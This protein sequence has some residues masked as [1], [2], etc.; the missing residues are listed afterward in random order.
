[1]RLNLDGIRKKLSNEKPASVFLCTGRTSHQQNPLF[2]P[3]CAALKETQVHHVRVDRRSLWID[4]FWHLLQ[5]IKSRPPPEWLVAFG[6][7]TVIDTAK[8]ICAFWNL[9]LSS[10]EEFRKHVESNRIAPTP[11][12]PLC[13]IPTT[14]GTGSEATQ[15]AVC[16]VGME[17]YSLDH[18]SLLPKDHLLDSRAIRALDSTVRAHTFLDAVCQATESLWAVGSTQESQKYAMDALERLLANGLRSFS[19]T[20]S[21][22][23]LFAGLEGAHLAG[24]AINISRTTAPHALSYYLTARHD[25]PHG[26]AVSTTFSELARLNFEVGQDDCLDPA[27]PNALRNR[28]DLIFSAWRCSSIDEFCRNF[29]ALRKELGVAARFHDLG[30]SPEEFE[31]FLSHLPNPER[32]KN[33]PRRI[34]PNMIREVLTPLF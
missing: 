12:A 19:A 18:P 13:A 14:A 8:L 20:A 6:G 24:K 25:M 11:L 31:S 17:K 28:F 30:L 15:F 2:Q 23:I 4:R 33:N 3:L 34:S 27:G 32:M 16:F 21:N 9:D 10:E 29:D 22:D 26:L 1:M 5:Q 7:G